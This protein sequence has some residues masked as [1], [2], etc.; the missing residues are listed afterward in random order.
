MQPSFMQD[1]TQSLLCLL[2]EFKDMVIYYFIF[3]TL[4][5]STVQ[6]YDWLFNRREDTVVS[7]QILLET[8]LVHGQPHSSRCGGL[9][10]ND[11]AALWQMFDRE[12]CCRQLRYS[13]MMET[14][15]I[16][17][18][19]YPIRHTFRE[20]VER[21]RFLI[22]GCPPAHKVRR[23]ATVLRWSYTV[24]PQHTKGLHSWIPF[25]W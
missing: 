15:R 23:V 1:S 21:Y 17:R 19:G 6:L 24:K 11:D 7:F 10:W 5:V 25:V 8:R 20:F 4:L 22:N 12:L 16:R 3:S 9:C 18:A 2:L 14:I 13:G